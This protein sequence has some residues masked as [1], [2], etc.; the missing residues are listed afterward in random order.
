MIGEPARIRDQA[1]FSRADVTSFVQ[2]EFQLGG[3]I[4]SQRKA[5]TID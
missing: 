1:I 2:C 4:R 3:W 5:E